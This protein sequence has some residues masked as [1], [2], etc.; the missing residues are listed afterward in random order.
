MATY[1][2]AFLDEFCCK[3]QGTR[4]IINFHAI[5]KASHNSSIIDSVVLIHIHI[6][7]Y[8]CMYVCMCA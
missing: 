2:L 4:L 6:C 3:F 5:I 1:I 7:M 8:V